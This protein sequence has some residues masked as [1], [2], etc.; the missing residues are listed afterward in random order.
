MMNATSECS[1]L[2]Y[3]FDFLAQLVCFSLKGYRVRVETLL[4]KADL[5][6]GLVTRGSLLSGEYSQGFGW[7]SSG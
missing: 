4:T 7:G 6:Q 3:F 5:I 1:F 2:L